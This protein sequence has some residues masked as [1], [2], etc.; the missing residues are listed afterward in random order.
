MNKTQKIRW[1]IAHEPA[2]LFLRTAKAFSK[3]VYD[4]TN[5]AVEIEIFTLSEFAKK[6]RREI[7]NPLVYMEEGLVEMSQLHISH[8]WKYNAP[9]FMALELPFLFNDHDHVARVVEGEI[10]QNMLNSLKEKSPVRGLAFTYSGG[11]R[12]MLSDEEINTLADFKNLTF[13]TGTN[14]IAIDT[15]EA[16]GGLPDPQ[17]NDHWGL[18]LHET[19]KDEH[20]A[21]DTTLPRVPSF[22]K[23]NSKKRYI[24]DTKHS[25]FLTTII[26]SEKWWNSLTDELKSAISASAVDA[27]RLERQWSLDDAKEMIKNASEQGLFYK[28]LDQKEM[29]KFY[30]LTEPL[31]TKYKSVFMPGFIDQLKNS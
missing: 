31:Y 21:V 16:V 10:G 29:E 30:S 9:A 23:G 3:D 11:Y 13:Y 28:E 19:Q 18:S 20:N 15:I 5:G 22:V 25:I 27:A 24:T 26:V 7:E 14:P 12:V 17:V 4:R 1:L 6:H 8:L 2:E